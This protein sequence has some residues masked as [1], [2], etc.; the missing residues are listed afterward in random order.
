MDLKKVRT[1]YEKLP[2]ALMIYYPCV[3]R[4]G[5]IKQQIH[6]W[7]KINKIVFEIKELHPVEVPNKA[8]NFVK[9]CNVANGIRF[10]SKYITYSLTKR[11]LIKVASCG[12]YNINL[13]GDG[14]P[15]RQFGKIYKRHG[16]PNSKA[17]I[18]ICGLR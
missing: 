18:L 1:D 4:I 7:L 5:T 12:Y 3:P 17:W 8:Q 16:N 9:E 13:R 14:G 2:F 15:T 11:G 10:C 6:I